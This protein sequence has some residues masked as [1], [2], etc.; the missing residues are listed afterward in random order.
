M[1]RS[2]SATKAAVPGLRLRSTL[3]L[4]FAVHLPLLAVAR[5]VPPAPPPVVPTEIVIESAVVDAPIVANAPVPVPDVAIAAAANVA[6][7]VGTSAPTTGDRAV[8]T[9][10]DAIVAVPAATAD[11]WGAAVRPRVSIDLPPG[12]IAPPP[13]SAPLPSPPETRHAAETALRAALDASDREKGFGR[14]GPLV[15]TA[16]GVAMASRIPVTSAATLV[17]VVDAEGKV[18][19]VRASV[20]DA[21]WKDLAA[22]LRRAMEAK[23]VRVP[24]GARGLEIAI[25]IDSRVRTAGGHVRREDDKG[26]HGWVDDKNPDRDRPPS[27]ALGTPTYRCLEGCTAS[28]NIDPTDALLGATAKNTRTIEVR[29]LSEKRL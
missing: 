18:V 5:R 17:A 9:E 25:R 16:H 26:G 10:G 24:T 4:A 3:V 2:S 23:R 1:V 22:S 13:S 6:R 7:A 28:G 14:S 27:L 12:A 29:T 21:A 11:V 8:V 20:D 15:S 19:D